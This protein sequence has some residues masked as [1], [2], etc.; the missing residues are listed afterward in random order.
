M[1]EN[2]SN[3]P[4]LIITY[5]PSKIRSLKFLLKSATNMRPGVGPTEQLPDKFTSWEERNLQFTMVSFTL[6]RISQHQAL[7]S[8]GN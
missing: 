6:Q 2:R 8:Q 4:I 1:N 3:G 5:K 7:A